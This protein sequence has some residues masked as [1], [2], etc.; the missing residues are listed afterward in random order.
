MT[1]KSVL[2]IHA[3]L[4]N[5]SSL[6]NHPAR[7][8][9]LRAVVLDSA[10]VRARASHSLRAP[11]SLVVVA[12]SLRTRIASRARALQDRRVMRAI[13]GIRGT[14]APARAKQHHVMFANQDRRSARAQEHHSIHARRTRKDAASGRQRQ[15]RA[16]RP[17]ARATRAHQAQRSQVVAPRRRKPMGLRAAQEHA[18]ADRAPR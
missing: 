14:P 18:S 12:L 17:T 3:I 11:R 9:L 4:L 13:A 15:R 5:A 2:L 1:T 8:A 16:A 6:Q 7:R 10:M